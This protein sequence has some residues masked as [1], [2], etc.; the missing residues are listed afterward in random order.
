MFYVCVDG[1]CLLLSCYKTQH[2]NN[3]EYIYLHIYQEKEIM[4]KNE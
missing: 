3:I 4:K 2:N 1:I